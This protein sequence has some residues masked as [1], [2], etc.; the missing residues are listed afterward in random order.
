[1]VQYKHMNQDR[2]PWL[3]PDWRVLHRDETVQN[4]DWDLLFAEPYSE[5]DV[6]DPE[7]GWTMTVAEITD[8]KEGASGLVVRKIKDDQ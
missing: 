2:Y 1:M 6:G 5:W 8:H 4:G 7:E 3:H